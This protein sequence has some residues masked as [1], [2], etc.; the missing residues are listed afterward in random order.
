MERQLSLFEPQTEE[1]QERFQLFLEHK[2]KTH[3]S[4]VNLS[5]FMGWILWHVSDYKKTLG[6]SWTDGLYKWEQD[7][8]TK[9]LEAIVGGSNSDKR[10]SI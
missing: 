1:Y 2:G 7:G 4:E 10:N 6:K 3:H 9:Y 5:E 8:F